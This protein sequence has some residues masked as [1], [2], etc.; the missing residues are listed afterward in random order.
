MCFTELLWYT[1]TVMI[2]VSETR[3]AQ[4]MICSV[5]HHTLYASR[6]AV[7]YKYLVKTLNGGMTALP[8]KAL[9]SQ[10]PPGCVFA[11]FWYTAGD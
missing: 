11:G 10:P 1:S 6:T 7:V 8:T 4:E 2:S 3:N 5:P 9:G